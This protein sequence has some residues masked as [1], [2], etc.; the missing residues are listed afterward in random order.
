V[1]LRPYQEEAIEKLRKAMRSRPVL[2]MPTG[3]GKTIVA[4]AIIRLTRAR[5]GTVLFV[6]PNREVVYQSRDKIEKAGVRAGIFMAQESDLD[7][8]VTVATIQTLDSR[9]RR[10][11][12]VPDA[13]LVILDEA[14]HAVADSWLRVVHHYG[15]AWLFGMT[16]TPCRRDGKGLGK[17]FGEI[18]EVVTIADLIEQGHLA[19]FKWFARPGPD[20]SG[21]RIRAGDYQAGQLEE[22]MSGLSGNLIAHYRKHLE[23]K[24]ALVFA[25]TVAHS[26]S[27]AERFRAEGISAEHVD[28]DTPQAERTRVFDALRDGSLHVVSN[29][30]LVYE[31][32]D[33]PSLAGVILARPTASLGLARQMVGRALRPPGPAVILDHAG[34]YERHR[35][36]TDP[37]RWTLEEEKKAEVAG[38]APTKV[39]PAC[40]AVIPLGCTTCPECGEDLP[41]ADPTEED[42]TELVEVTAG[43]EKKQRLA[44]LHQQIAIAHGNGNK[45]GWVSY[46]YKDRYG[47]WPP[48][49]PSYSKLMTHEEGEGC[50]FCDSIRERLEKFAAARRGE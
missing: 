5:G 38:E 26:M 45:I 28:A 2:V 29:V 27:I 36:P 6:S 34:I 15:G 23:G 37:I 8:D 39:C 25:C 22:R 3:A 41:R 1:Q 33:A 12:P 24:T 4:A 42:D 18:V 11:K 40:E 43:D 7:A 50:R 32:F 10:R 35:L 21:L 49:M 14:H 47:V 20:L 19:N 44:F 17:V 30:G 13:D 46:R 16:A 48:R 9:I 31:G